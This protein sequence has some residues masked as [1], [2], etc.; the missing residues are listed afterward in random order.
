MNH[1][2]LV[3]IIIPC[4]NQQDFIDYTSNSPAIQTSNIND[5]LDYAGS[6]YVP[7]KKIITQI[8]SQTKLPIIDN[9]KNNK[10]KIKKTVYNFKKS[11]NAYEDD[12]DEY[13]D[14]NL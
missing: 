14:D 3:S 7:N 10:P 12:Y 6:C 11:N 1:Q 8:Q 9:N 2:P 5:A 4:Y 13:N